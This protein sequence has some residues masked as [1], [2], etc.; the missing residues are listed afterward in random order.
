ME[1]EFDGLAMKQLEEPAVDTESALVAA[2]DSV[3]AM[4]LQ[5]CNSN[6]WAPGRAPIG[7]Y[8]WFFG[9]SNCDWSFQGLVD[10]FEVVLGSAKRN[11]EGDDRES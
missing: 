7:A 8:L 4:Y 6:S 9:C 10:S 11:M 5:S 3:A 2:A 1:A